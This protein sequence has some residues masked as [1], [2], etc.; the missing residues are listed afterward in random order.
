MSL[1]VLNN[2][3]AIYAENNLNNTN[4]SLSKTLQQ[5]SSG[6]KI[7]SGADDAAGLSLVNGLQ[8]NQTALTQSQTNASEGVAM[9]KVA[10]GALSQ[11]TNLLNR[12]VTLATEASNGS[13]TGRSDTAANQE[14]QSILDEIN[15]IGTTTTYNQQAV[16]NS[17]TN[18]YTGDSSTAGAS[19]NDLNIR[20]LSSSNL[21]DTSGAMAYSSGS[22]N[23]NVFVDLS[24][25]AAGAQTTA[26]QLGDTLNVIGV[27]TLTVNTPFQLG[28]GC[29]QQQFGRHRHGLREHRAGH[30][31]R[32]Q[33]LGSGLDGQLYHGSTAGAVPTVARA[34]GA[35]RRPGTDQHRHHDLRLGRVRRSADLGQLRR[36]RYR[37][38][39]QSTR[40][41]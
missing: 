31:Q 37:P 15:N 6:S 10:D 27:T 24:L 5:L 30:D 17:T 2:L 34:R 22:T 25:D 21:G 33:Q 38:P 16:F 12:A 11:V 35:S 4:N 39:A 7:N 28:H 18:I 13:L 41:F 9:L 29:G 32:H 40:I 23:S 8:A 20:S 14:Y 19:I 36:H 26:A 3:S 1:G